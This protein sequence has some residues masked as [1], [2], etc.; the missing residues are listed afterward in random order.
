M[1]GYPVSGHLDIR[2]PALR[3]FRS[4]AKSASRISLVVSSVVDPDPCWIRFQEL[5]GPGSGST[6]VNFVLN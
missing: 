6:L 4:Q 3:L 1:A 2:Y 5:C